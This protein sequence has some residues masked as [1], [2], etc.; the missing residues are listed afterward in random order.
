MAARCM[1]RPFLLMEEQQSN[2]K[3]GKVYLVGA[4][5]GDPDLMT[6]KAMRLLQSADVVL[7]DRLVAPEIVDMARRDAE[8]IYVGKQ[9]SEHAVPQSEINQLLVELAQQGQRVVRLKGGDP[10][11]FGRGG[12][13][14]ELLA[15]KREVAKLWNATKREGMTLVPLV[16]YFND[17][18]L[19]KL[20]IATAKGKKTHDK[21][22]T[23]AKR[24]W[25]RQKQ[26]LLKEG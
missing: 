6:F 2:P 23:Q 7:Y 14:I 5:P 21:R 9:R 18:G 13:E 19:V 12:E 24:D 1:D 25:G 17:R 16:M 4:G 15:S 3:K 26:R 22:E 8:R 10:F 11:I 20:K